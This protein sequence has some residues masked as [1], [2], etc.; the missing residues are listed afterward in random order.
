[1]LNI[2]FFSFP[3]KTTQITVRIYHVKF[4]KYPCGDFLI[5]SIAQQLMEIEPV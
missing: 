1:M 4:L 5:P 3:V 2:S